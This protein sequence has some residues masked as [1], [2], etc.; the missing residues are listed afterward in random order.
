MESAD[1]VLVHNNLQDIPSAIELSRRTLKTIKQNLFWAFFYNVIGIPIAAGVLYIFG[2]PL[3]NP[4]YAALAMSFSS[5]S[6]VTNALRLRTFKP[7][8]GE[9][10]P[11]KGAVA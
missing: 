11:K 10:S 6:V 3:L 1:I 9:N 4:I 5:V 7:L 8:R 2:G